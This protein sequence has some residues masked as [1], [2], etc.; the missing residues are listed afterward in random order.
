MSLMTGCALLPPVE[1]T[2]ITDNGCVWAKPIYLSEPGIA[3]L[4]EAQKQ[5]PE[6]R[7][8]REAIVLHNRLYERI[9]GARVQPDGLV[10]K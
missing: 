6:V 8:D 7:E 5:Y 9:C 2:A 3:A 10:P 4:R 1:V